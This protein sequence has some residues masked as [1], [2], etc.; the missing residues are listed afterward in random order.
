MNLSAFPFVRVSAQAG[1]CSN[2]VKAASLESTR[3]RA[4]PSRKEPTIGVCSQWF[5]QR[6]ELGGDH[7]WA[8]G[9]EAFGSL[10]R[11]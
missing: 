11:R 5:E 10:D 9:A 3:D 1:S 7:C 8:T 6:S 4:S 2:T